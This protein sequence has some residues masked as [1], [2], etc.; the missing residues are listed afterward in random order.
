[1]KFLDRQDEMSRLLALSKR[2]D[3]GLAVVTGRRRVG[4]TRLLVEWVERSGGVYFV[5]DQS[6][7]EV[8][9]HYLTVALATRLRGLD[10]VTFADWRSLLTGVAERAI[11]AKWTGPLVLDEIPYLVLQA[12]ELPSV[13]QH[14]I[15]HD[16]KRA[17]LSVAIAGSSQRMMQGLVMNASAP[18]FGR[19]RELLDLGPLPPAYARDAF[20]TRNLVEIW[21]AWGGIPR[22]WELASEER[23]PI[24]A[25]IDRLVLDPLGPLHREPDHILLEEVPSALEVRPVLD[26]I[27]GGAHRVSEIA[28]R[29]G[30]PATSLARPLDRLLGMGLATREVPFEE[31]GSKRVLYRIADPFFRMWFRVVA[32]NR[33]PLATMSPAARR[34]LLAKYWPGLVG[35]TWEE[36]CRNAV[37]RLGD[38][39][40][41]SRWWRGNEPEWD[42]VA[43]SID[44]TRLLVGEVKLRGSQRDVES[45]LRRP[46]PPFA[47]RRTVVRAL[48]AATTRSVLR[49]PGALV[50]G[51]DQV[52]QPAEGRAVMRP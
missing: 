36:L 39:S 51:P 3:G 40:T 1:M 8:Q 7:P 41:A 52:F 19:A 5:A 23:G 4:K 26:A 38:W 13:L 33:G 43:E 17:R 31:P 45:L 14:F 11:E 48:F 35:Q 32:P 34:A 42:V 20:R 27:G 16:A 50:I 47:G 29:M 25:R 49:A 18:L 12:P 22:Y 6:S 24:A 2:R 46:P 28:G 9:R 15:D 10:G 21:T 44:R 37:P 30:R